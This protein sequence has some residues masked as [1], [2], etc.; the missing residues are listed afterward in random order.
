MYRGEVNKVLSREDMSEDLL[1][2]Y[3]TGSNVEEKLH[4]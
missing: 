4:A 1:M 2:Y 3:S